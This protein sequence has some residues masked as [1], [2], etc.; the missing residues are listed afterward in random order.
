M[1]RGESACLISICAGLPTERRAVECVIRQSHRIVRADACPLGYVSIEVIIV[2]KELGSR[3]VID[4]LE[5]ITTRVFVRLAIVHCATGNLI[6]VDGAARIYKEITAIAI[7]IEMCLDNMAKT[8]YRL[9]LEDFVVS[10]IISK[11]GRNRVVPKHP[12]QRVD[13]AGAV[14]IDSNRRP[15]GT[16]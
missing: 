3:L 13:I 5:L 8:V 6:A 1:A 2:M 10:R 9:G 12:S 14:I 16:P 7:R 11:R 15:I 4:I